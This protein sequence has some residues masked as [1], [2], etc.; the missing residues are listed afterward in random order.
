MDKLCLIG[1]SHHHETGQVCQKS[2]VK[3]PCMGRAIGPDEPGPVNRKAHGQALDCHVMHDLIVT[4]LQECGVKRAEGFQAPR[5]HPCRKGHSMLFGNAH[6]KAAAREAFGKQVQAGAI[7][8]G[9]RD[10]HDLVIGCG[11]G[12]Q[13][14][15]EN[16]SI[17]GRVGRG[18][19]LHARQHVEFARCMA[20]VAG[21]L[22]RGI[23]LALFGDHMDQHRPFGAGV[24]RAQNRHKLVQ[25][26]PVNRP[27]IG[28]AQLFK[29]GAADGHTLEHLF[30]APRPFLKRFRKQADSPF[31]RRFQILKRRTGVK[32]RQVG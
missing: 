4:A 31:C 5:G 11:L 6:I 20:F 24:N 16:R 9:G 32:P 21:G 29:Q 10:R 25:I 18:L 27:D 1:G 14:L 8:H 30:R 17:A 22:C 15:G 28:K 26:M 7:G 12:D 3:R 19:G 23:A 2:H 13:R